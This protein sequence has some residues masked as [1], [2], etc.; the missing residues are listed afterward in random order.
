MS[1]IDDKIK[2]IAEQLK[3]MGVW[4]PAFSTLVESCAQLSHIRDKAFVEL[5]SNGLVIEE[6]SREGESRKKSN[7]AYAIYIET[8]KELRAVLIELSM[9]VKSSKF[10]EGDELD[11]LNVMLEE[12]QNAV[13]GEGSPKKTKKRGRPKAQNA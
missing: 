13:L 1:K 12:I 3:V 10:S 2:I 11:K 4:S 6:L 8:Q 5:E 7:P 9:T